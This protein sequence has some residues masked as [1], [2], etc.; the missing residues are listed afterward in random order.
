MSALPRA[1]ETFERCGR[2]HDRLQQAARDPEIMGDLVETLCPPATKATASF[3]NWGV[4][5]RRIRP[6]VKRGR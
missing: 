2:R 1:A 5:V 6:Q 3:L 4:N